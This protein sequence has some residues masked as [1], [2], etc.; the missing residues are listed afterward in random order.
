MKRTPNRHAIVARPMAVEV[1]ICEKRLD[2][3]LFASIRSAKLREHCPEAENVRRDIRRKRLR[4]N[5]H[6]ALVLRDAFER[7]ADDEDVEALGQEIV[8]MARQ[9]KKERDGSVTRPLPEV[10]QF[11]EHTEGIAEEAE[12][13]FCYDPSPRTFI[14]LEESK[15]R[16]INASMRLLET[17]RQ[18]AF[19]GIN[20]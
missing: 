6:I 13:A 12:L 17:A 11:E 20:S 15:T 1:A 10:H 9:W 4:P 5:K 18:Q 14:Q 2:N 7:G 3:A 16:H 8:A 19:A